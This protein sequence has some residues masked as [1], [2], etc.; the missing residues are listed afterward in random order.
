[1]LLSPMSA[2]MP[3]SFVQM[4]IFIFLFFL[5]QRRRKRIHADGC[6]VFIDGSVSARTDVASTWT[7]SCSYEQM[8]LPRGR[9][10]VCADEDWRPYR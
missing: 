3:F 4:Q 10:R 8:L 2:K 6:H 9:A 5:R 1:M 7:G